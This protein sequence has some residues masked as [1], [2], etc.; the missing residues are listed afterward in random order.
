[1]PI[2]RTPR[3]KLLEG[4]FDVPSADRSERRWRVTLPIEER[5]WNIGLVVGPSGCG[6]TTLARECFGRQPEPDWPSDRAIVDAFPPSLGIK[7]I[8]A[9][10]S[11]VGFSSPP[12]WLRPYHAL[13]TGEQFRVRIARALAAAGCSSGLTASERTDKHAASPQEPPAV[14]DEFTSVVDRTV[15]RIGSAAIARTV[16]AAG[17]KFVAV[18]CHYD[19][20]EWL[21]PDWMYEPAV[22]QFSWRSLR[23]RPGIALEICRVHRS[24][25][26]LFKHHHYLSGDLNPSA[27]CYV[28][29]VEGQPAAFAAV[30]SG[31]D[32]RGGH[33][34]EHRVVCLPDFQ[35]V[36]IGNAL[37]EFVASLYATRKRYFSRTSHPGMIRHR[38]RSPNWRCISRP[39]FAARHAQHTFA[40]TGSARR[41]AASFRFVG[42]P[43]PEDAVRLGVLRSMTL[44]QIKREERQKSTVGLTPDARRAGEPAFVQRSIERGHMHES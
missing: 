10:L 38:L 8:V 3:V 20:L 28:A 43:R 37:S 1:M 2:E 19:V 21:D 25:W 14:V 40:K 17:K 11:S 36:G 12:A 5:D 13:S 26:R 44:H 42:P 18:T 9:L 6:K 7:E 41:L 32:S 22:D 30:I 15:A 16:R 33:F 23:G 39:G 31:P 4:L 34:R 27:Q 24:A 29:F 35:G